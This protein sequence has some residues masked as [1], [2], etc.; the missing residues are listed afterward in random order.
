MNIPTIL[1]N[2]L[3]TA[4]VLLAAALPSVAAE[5]RPSENVLLLNSYHP[6]FSWSDAEEAGVIE[7]LRQKLPAMDILIEYLDAKRYPEKSNLARMKRFLIDKYHG[8]KIDLIIALD[9]AA[10]EILTDPHTTLFPGVPIVFA[11]I[12]SFDKYADRGRKRITGVL[13]TQDIRN[14]IDTALRLRPGTSEIL[15][16][17]DMTSSGISAQKALEAIVPVYKG[18]VKIRFLPPCTFEE[19]QAAVT[20]LSTY[21]IILLNSYTVD[22]TGKALSTKDSTRLIVSAAKVPVYG[23]HENRFGDGI[24]GGHLLSGREQGRK[25]ARIGLRI[26]AGENPDSIPIEKAG[27]TVAMFDYKQMERFDIPVSKLPEGSIVI[28]K[29]ASVFTTHRKFA[30]TITAIL[31]LL[32]IM[33]LLLAFFSVRLLQARTA[34]RKKTEELD[35]IFSLSLDLLSVASLD[36]KF[37]RLNPAWESTLGYSP[38]ELEG[39]RFVDLVHPDDV[40]ATHKAVSELSAG[41]NLIDFVNRY[42]CKD[43]SYRWIEWRATP[44]QGFF[45]YAA[46]RDITER[47]QSEEKLRRLSQAWNLAQK[48]GKIG[49]WSYDVETRE[50]IWSDQ[51]FL[52]LGFDPEKAVPD[53]ETFLETLHPEDREKFDEAFQEALNGT[54]YNIEARVIHSGGTIHWFNTQGFPRA[55]Q[56]GNIVKLFGTLQDIT[57]RKQAEVAL[58]FTQYAIDKASD[59]AFWMTEDGGIFYVNDAACRALGYSREELLKLSVP[60]LDQSTSPEAFAEH[61]QNLRKRQSITFETMGRTKDGRTFPVEIRANFVVFDGKEYNCAFVTDISERKRME[62]SLRENESFQ[63]ALLQAIPDRIWL[64]DRSGVYLACNAMFE[65]FFGAKEEAIVGKTDYDFVDQD[66][67]DFFRE[68]DRKAIDSGKPRKNEE[69]ITFADDGHRALLETIKMPMIDDQGKLVGVL[70]VARDITERKK[71][72]EEKIKLRSQLQQAQKMQ[73]VGRLAGGVAHDFNNMLGVILGYGE[74]ALEQTDPSQQV[75]AAL[76]EIMKA[77]RRSTEITSQLLAF[78]RK[79]TISPKVLDINKTVAGMTGMLRRFIGENIDLAWLPGENVWRVKIDPVQIDQILANLCVNARDAIENVGKVTI[80]TGNVV[81]DESYCAHHLGFLPGEYVLLAVSDNGCGMD[82]EI[83]G[84]IFEP[85]FTT[86]ESGKGT[87]LGLSTVYGIVKQNNGFINLYSEPG[88]GT[89]FKIYLPRQITNAEYLP[90]KAEEEPAESGQETIL[91]VEDELSILKMT[92]LMLESLGYQVVASSTPSEAIRLAQDYAGE[93][94]LL[95]TDVIMPEM[96]GRDLAESIQSIHPNIKCLFMSGYTA[97]VIA[98]HGVLDEGVNF[99][100]KPFS[101]EKLGTKVRE[102]LDGDNT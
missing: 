69:W 102:T 8:K 9:D 42:R 19:A 81:F 29:P 95:V 10:V 43:G 88:Q 96:N 63:R 75:H 37:L 44:Y 99:I 28:N 26:L 35:R 59:Q 89:T 72:E 74:L 1:T 71:T 86:K 49:H 36:G 57:E 31:I 38:D 56:D 98:H 51:M 40:D 68:H 94:H 73:S 77:A 84:N 32:V 39:R 101:K 7:Q 48:M 83:A 53:Y 3:A 16:I 90:E 12:T 70:G 87:G 66:L 67:A 4:F 62:Q 80:E 76:R 6:G 91:L 97:N 78:A 52:V 82:A 2:A 41:K 100:P 22:S 21:S 46:A 55:D 60:D 14:T 5:S 34:L 11:G 25:A 93:I 23:V 54:P 58:R 65:R 17:S 24:V 45:A 33:I 15:A 47:R 13:E 27:T 64:K 79:Q 20:V 61:W 50:P 18:R 85:F 92:K 30:V